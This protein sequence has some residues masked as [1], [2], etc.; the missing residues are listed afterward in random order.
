ML[1]NIILIS[2][3]VAYAICI[4]P[5]PNGP[6][7]L[8]SCLQSRIVNLTNPVNILNETHYIICFVESNLKESNVGIL[9]DSLCFVI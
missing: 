2:Y 3:L 9:F 1:L 4:M 7:T 6:V 8:N 5:L